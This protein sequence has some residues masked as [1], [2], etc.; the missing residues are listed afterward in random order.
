MIEYSSYQMKRLCTRGLRDRKGKPA[1][2]Y[3]K[4][5]AEQKTSGKK[6]KVHPYCMLDLQL[7]AILQT[8]LYREKKLEILIEI[9]RLLCLPEIAD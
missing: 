7:P 9:L 8:R 1:N 6:L 2:K 5:L 4:V 3:R